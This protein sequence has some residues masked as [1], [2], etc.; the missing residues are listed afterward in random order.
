MKGLDMMP[1]VSCL[2]SGVAYMPHM[3]SNMQS[4]NSSFSCVL[5]PPFRVA[6][7][8]IRSG[9]FRPCQSILSSHYRGVSSLSPLPS[10]WKM[11]APSCAKLKL[12]RE[13]C[14]PLSPTKAFKDITYDAPSPASNSHTLFSCDTLNS[15]RKEHFSLTA[16]AFKGF[17]HDMAEKP[18]WW[19]RT[20]ACLPYLMPLHLTWYFAG[21]SFH[22]RPFVEKSDYLSNPYNNFLRRLPS[23]LLMAYTFTA[24]FAVV[25]RKEWPHFFRFHVI[26]A[27]LLE[28]WMHIIIIVYGWTPPFVHWGN[29]IGTHIWAAVT[30]GFLMMIFQ[31]MKCTLAGRYADIPLVSDAANIHLKEMV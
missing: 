29:N 26:M 24:C 9:S 31:C 8:S 3:S 10:Q 18:K 20:L 13:S 1:N 14:Y 27:I 28:N 25:K 17:Y 21:E 11:C 4:Y 30:V 23:W 7:S 19:W 5:R 15:P 6:I 2:A 16:R 22:L 12:P